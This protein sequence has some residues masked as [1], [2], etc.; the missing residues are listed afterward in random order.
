MEVI[1]IPEPAGGGALD[2]V[3]ALFQL[4]SHALKA[5]QEQADASQVP[6]RRPRDVETTA[7]GAAFAAGLAVGVWGSA[8]ELAGLNAAETT[9]EPSI[10]AE[11]CAAK[12]VRW[13]DAVQR[14]LD[15]AV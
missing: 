5:A 13:Q 3:R 1:A 8:D 12:L 4:Q 7:R 6:V 14:T 2:D 11:A 10:G 9:F 15:L